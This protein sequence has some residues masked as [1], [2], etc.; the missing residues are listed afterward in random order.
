MLME[1][2]SPFNKLNMNK[3]NA[4]FLRL[5]LYTAEI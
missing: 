1:I 5:V 4:K 3:I 2:P